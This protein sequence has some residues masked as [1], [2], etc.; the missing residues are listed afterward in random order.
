MS[1]LLL[2]ALIAAAPPPQAPQS[3]ETG[4][5]VVTGRRLADT[6]AALK[7][8]LA[9]KCP[10]NEDIDASIAHAENQMIAG[11]YAAAR[12]TLKR[13]LGRNSDEAKRYPEP[14]SDLYRANA[15][16]ASHLGFDQ[17]YRISTI[18]ILRSLKAG[19]PPADARLFGARMEI[20]SMKAR[21]DGYE[22][23]IREYDELAEDARQAG[24][25]DIAALAE[26][27]AIL[28][29]MRGGAARQLPVN[30]ASVKARLQRFASSQVP[31]ERIAAVTAKAMLARLALREGNEAEAAALMRELSGV[32][33][34]TPS[35]LYA[36]PYQLAQQEL[37]G[38][39][40]NQ[41]V[42]AMRGNVL[43]RASG[44]FEDKWIDVGFWVQAD[45]RVTEVE[46]LRKDGP[47]DWATPLLK[48]LAGRVYSS[49]AEGT[50]IY[51]LERYTYTAGFE[52]RAG[53]RIA[54]RSPRARVEYLDLS[55][56][57]DARRN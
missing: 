57:P 55:T 45:G 42:D 51:R 12:T 2:T 38:L 49:P 19:L 41:E 52:T 23:A 36:P 29:E 39:N 15:L 28:A 31:E 22:R 11:D 20:A 46:I 32:M 10:V 56:Y 54:Q 5:I 16:L 43:K 26:V 24:R 48:S 7:A 53:T 21:L 33:G 50:P 6:E 35:L 25:P 1:I 8:C 17:D 37:P 4:A 13:S 40:D 44:N 30:N 14:V 9:R 27:R 34:K 18:N 3:A 47:T